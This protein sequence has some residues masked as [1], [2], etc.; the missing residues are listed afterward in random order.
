MKKI[1]SLIL[2]LSV[3][4]FALASCSGSVIG[5]V[6]VVAEADHDVVVAH[7]AGGEI[8]IAI[9]PEP[10]ATVAINT[11]K[12]QGYNYSIKLN[13]SEE[14]NKISDEPLA[15]GCIVA[16]KAFTQG[17]EKLIRD[18][19]YEYKNSIEF[20]GNAENKAEAAQMIVD[21]KI[22]P[23]LP[24]ATSALNNL[25]GSIVY[26][27]GEEMEQ[28]LKAFYQA[29]GITSPDD[30][31]YYKADTNST[32]NRSA[33][34]RIAV[35]NGPTGMGMAKLMNDSQG[36]TYEFITYDNPAKATAD[37]A[38]GTVDMACIPTNTA[39][40]LA[41]KSNDISVISIN[42]LG[43]LYV[44][45]KDGVEIN[46]VADLIDKVVYYGVPSSTT[47]PIFKYILTKNKIE[48]VNND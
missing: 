48:L 42:C 29:I 9:L 35:M 26:S 43:S 36:E 1:I 30:T 25:Y 21:A 22:L 24:I 4:T 39:A 33:K 10:K 40:V 37:L 46:S 7:I 5:A 45:V 41:N 6:N 16:N 34:I 32:G 13:L 2:A 14:W 18:F 47:E 23:K 38:A 11:A 27:D 44:V 3:L 19:L 31:F 20:I 12:A 15:M 28:T 17:N 8:D